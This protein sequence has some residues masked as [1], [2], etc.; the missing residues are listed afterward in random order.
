MNQKYNI[1][2]PDSAALQIL[3]TSLADRIWNL[4]SRESGFSTKFLTLYFPEPEEDVWDAVDQLIDDERAYRT[5]QGRRLKPI[6]NEPDQY[7]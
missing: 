2:D 1:L 6:W 7:D 4:I 3:E 5:P